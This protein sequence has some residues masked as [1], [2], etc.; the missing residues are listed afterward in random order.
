MCIR[1]RSTGILPSA[2]LD[3]LFNAL[4]G[5]LFA[6]GWW[7]LVDGAVYGA[8]HHEDLNIGLYFTVIFTALAGFIFNT[9][10]W[11]NMI[12]GEQGN[13]VM[14]AKIA[15]LLVYITMLACLTASIWV[16]AARGYDWPQAAVT[17]A[18]CL[19]IVGSTV[20]RYLPF[21]CKQQKSS[22]FEFM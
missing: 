9:I 8:H 13:T 21:T 1:D 11:D 2:M 5:F 19:I 16:G 20:A 4:G 14:A 17:V 7:F 15:T 3:H 6:A 22:K 18:V 10:P 12:G